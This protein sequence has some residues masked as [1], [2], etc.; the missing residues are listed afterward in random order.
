MALN[1]K[2][3]FENRIPEA[4]RNLV[5]SKELQ[6]AT[7][8]ALLAGRNISEALADRNLII[9]KKGTTG[10][11]FVT[12][13]DQLNEKLI[14]DELSASFPN[15]LFIGEEESAADEESDNGLSIANNKDALVWIVDPIDGTTNFVHG[16][17]SYC[18]SIGLTIN[19]ICVMGVVF[20][21][22][23]DELFQSIQGHGA[24]LNNVRINSTT[25]SCISDA[26][27]VSFHSMHLYSRTH[28]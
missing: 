8:V 6:V 21:P 26:I 24:F 19:K 23:R 28:E 5:Y 25:V 3:S 20:D 10:V 18:V 9:S 12:E 4:L 1:E 14:Y 7:R 27:V 17:P 2:I 11:D 15:Y 16:F 22:S 13:T